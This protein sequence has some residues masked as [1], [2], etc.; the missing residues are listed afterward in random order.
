MRRELSIDQFPLSTEEGL[1]QELGGSP[2]RGME[3]SLAPFQPSIKAF[4]K[5]AGY[6]HRASPALD[7]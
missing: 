7:A 3:E 4:L 2:G 5:T 6:S 1:S